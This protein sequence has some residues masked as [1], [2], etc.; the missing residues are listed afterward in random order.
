MSSNRHICLGEELMELRTERGLYR[1]RRAHL[2][3]LP[4]ELLEI[5]QQLDR[6]ATVHRLSAAVPQVLAPL[7]CGY[8]AERTSTKD[9]TPCIDGI[10]LH[11]FFENGIPREVTAAGRREGPQVSETIAEYET[12]RPERNILFDY[13]RNRGTNPDAHPNLGFP[14]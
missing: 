6:A 2:R 4:A 8:H 7:I 12:G 13:C 3:G 5:Q 14:F 1:H 11:L 10:H 9:W